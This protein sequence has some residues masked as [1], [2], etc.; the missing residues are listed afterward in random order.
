MVNTYAH[1]VPWMNCVAISNRVNFHLIIINKMSKRILIVIVQGGLG[2]QLFQISNGLQIA[3]LH[4]AC[5]KLFCKNENTYIHGRISKLFEK[6]E[7]VQSV[8]DIFTIH[9]SGWKY[10]DPLSKWPDDKDIIAIDGYFQSHKFFEDVGKELLSLLN[11]RDINVPQKLPIICP[12]RRMEHPIVALHVRRGDYVGLQKT[13]PLQSKKYYTKAVAQLPP[14]SHIV[15]FSDDLKW[16][17]TQPWLRFENHTVYFPTLNVFETLWSMIQCTHHIIANSTLSWWGAALSEIKYDTK[18]LVIAPSIWFGTNLT[19]DT[20][21][22]YK[23]YWWKVSPQGELTYPAN[24]WISICV[25]CYEMGGKGVKFLSEMLD[26]VERQTFRNYEV[27][28]S[29]HSENDE[30]Q[31][32]CFGKKVKYIRNREGRGSSSNNMNRAIDM[33]MGGVIKPLFQDDLLEGSE[34]L[35]R[36]ITD[37]WIISAAVVNDEINNKRYGFE[38]SLNEEEWKRGRNTVGGPSSIAWKR[39]PE[40]RFHNSLINLMDL[41]MYIRLYNIHGDPKIE[42]I[43]SVVTRLWNG[44]VTNTVVT[45]SLTR[46]ECSMVPEYFEI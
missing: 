15:V 40:L 28:I 8:K 21:D 16:C 18:P 11:W 46:E 43:P 33:S 31:H 6:F 27:V 14:N 25:P 30:I 20:R 23:S 41:Y 2:N 44:S 32:F 13:H 7:Q 24:P 19:H 29:D 10:A 35:Q 36:F 26:S 37:S 12:S 39:S 4:N 5:L 42:R 1:F 3:K 38:P 22:M 17:R 45:E 34:S 9:Q